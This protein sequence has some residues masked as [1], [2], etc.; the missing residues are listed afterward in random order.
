LGAS[1]P[2][3]IISFSSLHFIEA[4]LDLTLDLTLE[5]TEGERKNDERYSGWSIVI[6][7]SNT[8]CSYGGVW[9]CRWELV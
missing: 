5:N 2:A 7:E 4:R 6:D 1:A 9:S 3:L 8:L